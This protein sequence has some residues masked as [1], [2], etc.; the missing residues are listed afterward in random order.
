MARHKNRLHVVWN[1]F[2]EDY[3]L[4]R[5]ALVTVLLLVH[6]SIPPKEVDLT[7]ADWLAALQVPFTLTF[8]QLDTRKKVSSTA[9]IVKEMKSS[10]QG[11]WKRLLF[12]NLIGNQAAISTLKT[13]DSRSTE[14]SH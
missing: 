8:T 11:S 7:C 14:C 5:E 12:W 10:L 6:A 13:M 1:E 9:R 4:S 3:L 2:I